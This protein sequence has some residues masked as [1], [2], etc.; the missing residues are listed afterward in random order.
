[1]INIDLLFF[2]G[3][4]LALPEY[5]GTVAEFTSFEERMPEYLVLYFQMHVDFR[6][7]SV[8]VYCQ[9]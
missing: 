2:P 5:I 1:M 6:H 7:Q 3:L 9:D 8:D 4:G